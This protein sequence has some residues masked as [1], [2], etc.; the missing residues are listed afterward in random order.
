MLRIGFDAGYGYMKA[1]AGNGKK[2]IIPSLVGEGFKR[3]YGDIFGSGSNSILE[4]LHIEIDGEHFFVGE[5]ASLESKNCSYAFDQNKILHINTKVLLSTAIMLLADDTKEDIA[6]V[7]GLP[8]SDYVNQKKQMQNYLD[9][10]K[11]EAILHSNDKTVERQIGFKVAAV[12]PQAAGAI[13][14]IA[15]HY[16]FGVDGLIGCIDIGTKTTDFTVFAPRRVRLVENMSGTLDVGVHLIHSHILREIESLTGLRPSTPE[17]ERILRAKITIKRSKKYDLTAVIDAG[18]KDLS[19][20]IA[21]EIAKR[22]SHQINNFNMVF[23]AGG[24]AE[25]LRNEMDS[26]YEGIII[27]DDPEFLNAK[28]FLIV[29]NELVGQLG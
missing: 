23:L 9:T 12:F 4:N 27:P 25:L 3:Q 7:V 5:L 24:G 16:D 8:F 21:D 11:T 17:L 20:Q 15:E 6:I 1:V 10:F 2:I 22:W 18:K 14:Q 19:K 13:F 26:I 29:A 28:G